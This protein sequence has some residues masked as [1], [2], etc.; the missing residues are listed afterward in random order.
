M[1]TYAYQRIP[2]NC[3][4]LGQSY[5]GIYVGVAGHRR[6]L[7]SCVHDTRCRQSRAIEIRPDV[8]A[9]LFAVVIAAPPSANVC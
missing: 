2:L 1:T 7:L 3:P 9:M 8:E 4:P 6:T 5:V